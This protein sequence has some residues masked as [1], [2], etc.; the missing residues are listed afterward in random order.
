MTGIGAMHGCFRGE[1]ILFLSIFVLLCSCGSAT[2]INS[3]FHCENTDSD[4]ETTYYSYLKQSD[5]KESGFARGLE[6]GSL[7]YFKGEA[8][9]DDVQV[10]YDGKIDA[11]HPANLT[12]ASKD[13]LHNS[14]V[15]HTLKVDYQGT[16]GLSLFYSK[17]FY[18]TNR[19]ISASKKIWFGNDTYYPT[20][21]IDLLGIA[22]MDMGGKYLMDYNIKEANDAYFVFN[23]A[24]GFSNKTGSR[25]ID[26]EQ[27]GLIKGD[28]SNTQNYL[29][30]EGE[31][32]PRSGIYEDWL[33]CFCVFSLEPP[34]EGLDSPWPTKEI[35]Y[36]LSHPK[37][38]KSQTI[39]ECENCGCD[40]GLE[41]PPENCTRSTGAGGPIVELP[42]LWVEA[43]YDAE[44]SS[45]ARDWSIY[46]F[47]INVKNIGT[48]ALE[49]VR[50]VA[51]QQFDPD[52]VYV[53]SSGSIDDVPKDPYP[54]AP[55]GKMWLL[56]TLEPVFPEEE[57]M[58]TVLMKVNSS[59]H[60]EESIKFYAIYRI[61]SKTYSTKPV[62]PI[63]E[64]SGDAY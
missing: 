5:L 14:T 48:K 26:F 25:R 35:E 23:D 55:I 11:K 40:M 16:H 37:E 13:Y 29:A 62:E 18:N 61:G 43:F 27:E 56:G 10:Y 52:N 39:V 49:D 53:D 36:A 38:Q 19:A 3:H 60:L 1:L 57:S 32:N 41:C 33:P 58:K 7:N 9:V 28:I 22:K 8:T 63:G 12:N 31:F 44:E 64:V 45:S 24:L 59:G 6:T 54:A 30:I 15:D 51:Q 17:G 2:T 42:D 46:E 20:T 21:S 47:E 34:I 4:G 50:L